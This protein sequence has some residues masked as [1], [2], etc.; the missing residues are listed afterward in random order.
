M[1]VKMRNRRRSYFL[2]GIIIFL[3]VDA[4]EAHVVRH[5]EA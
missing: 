4:L 1:A 5:F 2:M 3:A